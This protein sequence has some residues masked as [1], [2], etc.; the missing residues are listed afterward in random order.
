MFHGDTPYSVY[1]M[2]LFPFLQCNLMPILFP[3]FHKVPIK[4]KG[5]VVYPLHVAFDKWKYKFEIQ[6][7]FIWKKILNA[8]CY[9]NII[10]KIWQ[11]QIN[12]G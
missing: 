6:Y 12:K 11:Q 3:P 7:F 9:L 4:K 1:P 8:Q 2:L 5:Y 10:K